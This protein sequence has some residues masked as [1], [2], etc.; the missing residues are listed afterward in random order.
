MARKKGQTKT[1]KNYRRKKQTN[2]VNNSKKPATNAN[3]TYKDSLF[4]DLFYSDETAEEN[5]RS[6]YNALHPEDMLTEKDVIEKKR[7]ENVFFNS[8]RN[9]I[10]GIFKHK[11]IVFGEHQSTINKNIPIRLFMYSGRIYEQLLD[12]HRKY[13]TELISLPTPEFYVFYNGKA[14]W[15]VKELK[16]SDAFED[17]TNPFNLELKVTLINIRAESNSDILK[18]CN[19]LNQY[20]KFVQ[21]YEANKGSTDRM[22]DTIKYCVEHDILKEYIKRKGKE[23]LSML[24]MDWDYEEAMEV[25]CEEGARRGEKK[26]EIEHVISFYQDG[27]SIERLARVMGR[28][29]REIQQILQE[30]NVPITH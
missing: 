1:I 27:D 28:T 6:L 19:I 24:T 9:D 3:R 8:L 15:D 26:K 13:E 21:V 4:T 18:R 10:T 22:G 29:V 7:L 17:K 23:V 25:A 12:G 14:N 11:I 30:N 5:L 20:S 2:T 16:L